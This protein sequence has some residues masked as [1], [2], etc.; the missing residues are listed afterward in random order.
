MKIGKIVSYWSSQH[1]TA[2]GEWVHP[3][4]VEML[5]EH[6]HSFNLDFP[7][8]PYVGDIMNAPVIILGANAGYKKGIT[9]AEF[10]DQAAIDTY[11]DRVRDP[12]TSDWSGMAQYYHG[13]N[14]RSL[15]LGGDAVWINACAY[16]S[17]K[18]SEEPQNRRLIEVLPSAQFTRRWLLEAVMPLAER[19]E[20]LV[21]ANRFGQW[22]LP[23]ELKETNGI[24]FDPAPVSSQVTSKPWAAVQVFLDENNQ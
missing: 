12:D 18:L 7:V 23:P 21:V 17:K 9:D 5:R 22:N 3:D 1:R 2:A 19:G 11:L 4:D 13:V 14:Y 10:P 16:R 15:L 20:R 8:S 6:D 24:V